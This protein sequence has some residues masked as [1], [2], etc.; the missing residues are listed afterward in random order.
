MKKLLIIMAL[1][2]VLLLPSLSQAVETTTVPRII[3]MS[4]K[5]GVFTPVGQTPY[6][7]APVLVRQGALEK[8]AMSR[9]GAAGL[10]AVAASMLYQGYKDHPD[11]FPQLSGWLGTLGYSLNPQTKAYNYNSQQIEATPGSTTANC[12]A[13]FL[14]ALNAGEFDEKRVFQTSAARS[15][16]QVATGY[17]CGWSAP[18]W[19]GTWN[20]PTGGIVVP[21]WGGSSAYSYGGCGGCQYLGKKV[22]W[23]SLNNAPV[24]EYTTV[25][26][27]KDVTYERMKDV[28]N[29]NS[30]T[31]NQTD[32]FRKAWEDIESA[33]RTA[34]RE[35]NST[36]G[37]STQ[38][39]DQIVQQEYKTGVG[40]TFLQEL[41]T[42]STALNTPGTDLS[43]QTTTN[44]TLED[45][46]TTPKGETSGSGAPICGVPPL[47]PC[48]TTGNWNDTLNTPSDLSNHNIDPNENTTILDETATNAG[49]TEQK[50]VLKAL[51]QQVMAAANNLVGKIMTEVN[52]WVGNNP[53]GSCSLGGVGVFGGTFS[54]SLCEID[55]SG[56][57]ELVIAAF[58]IIS[59]VTLVSGWRL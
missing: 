12:E 5:N 20:C 37:S 46:V 23:Y 28:F 27:L 53:A 7:F 32:G 3:D 11:L 33:A 39:I 34:M 2:M 52:R 29:T 8:V 48:E 13:A 21:Y 38:T 43:N 41:S 26:K 54:L 18:T 51:F 6:R 42:A 15:A 45:A 17:C 55:L 24:S 57:R 56:W 16:D 36:P 1:A 10:T 50:G 58:G 22:I 4:P 31:T 44:K 47:P 9:L 30:D 59:A 35:G 14:A 19:S 25:L 40:T 49:V